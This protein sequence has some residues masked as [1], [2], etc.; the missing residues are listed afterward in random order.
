MYL[1]GGY[2]SYYM[3]YNT[4]H[5]GASL[6]ACMQAIVH[7]RLV[8]NKPGYWTPIYMYTCTQH[9][10]SFLLLP[11]RVVG[12]AWYCELMKTRALKKVGRTQEDVDVSPNMHHYMAQVP[13][14]KC[15]GFFITVGCL[16]AIYSICVCVNVEHS[17]TPLQE[18]T[19]SDWC[20][21]LEPWGSMF[22]TC[23]SR[24]DRTSGYEWIVHVATVICRPVVALCSLS[25]AS[26]RSLST[27][28]IFFT[29][30]VSKIV[31]SAGEARGW[32]CR[33]WSDKLD[34]FLHAAH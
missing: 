31:S 9:G 15:L 14:C 1:S 27:S 34:G 30:V 20:T 18:V 5:C 2:N 21:G 25:G 28:V 17:V 19:Y 7:N 16:H 6:C 11:S 29:S 4:Q 22:E 23:A 13:T 10:T 32:A 12:C 3:W 26:A 33:G 8:K 24:L